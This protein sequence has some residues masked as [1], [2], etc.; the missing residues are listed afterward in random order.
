[1]VVHS[2]EKERQISMKK[3]PLI[4]SMLVILTAL[5]IVSCDNSPKINIYTVTFDSD[6][7]SKVDP[8]KIVEGE[9]AVRPEA[10]EKGGYSFEGWLDSA[11]SVF[12]F[13][14]KITSSITLKAQWSAIK[15]TYTVTFDSDEGS[16]VDPQTVAEGQ[17]AVMPEKAPQKTGYDFRGW[18]KDG[19]MYSFDETP[20]TS[21]I[22]L[23]A[24]WS[25]AL[26]T[27]TITFVSNGGTQVA[28]QTVNEGSK[29][30]RPA[31]PEKD[32]ASFWGWYRNLEDLSPFDFENETVTSDITLY[33]GWVEDV[34]VFRVTFDSKGG[35]E[36]EQQIVAEGYTATEPDA[37]TKENASFDGWL[38]SSGKPF[39]FDTKITQDITLTANWG[40]KAYTVTFDS[41]GGSSVPSQSVIEGQKA[42]KPDDPTREGCRFTGWFRSD[43]VK[44][45]FDSGITSDITLYATWE[46]ITDVCTVIFMVDGT[47]YGT[48]QTVKKWG[49][50]VK[51]EKDPEKER[52]YFIN[53]VRDSDDTAF[54]FE[55]DVVST[56][57]LTLKAT[58]DDEEYYTVTFNS[59]GGSPI[60]SLRIKKGE[61]VKRPANPTKD[62][63]DFM[64]WT[65]DGNTEY[66]FNDPVESDLTLTAKW[67][68]KCY[69]VAYTAEDKI[70]FVQTVNAGGRTSKPQ[71]PKCSDVVKT[72]D[73]WT[74]DGTTAFNFD[75]PINSNITL[76]AVWRD[77]RVG[78]IGPAGGYIFYD[79]DADNADGNKDGLISSEC[80]WRYLEA[81]REDYPETMRWGD[82]SDDNYGTK[83][84]IG[85]GKDNTIR[86]KNRGTK[87]YMVYKI[88]GKEF[89][90]YSDWFVPSRDE[91]NL[92]YENLHKKGL[93]SFR[94]DH[95][96]TSSEYYSD[97]SH[98]Y[99]YACFQDFA[100]G[101]KDGHL[102]SADDYL[103]LI[104]SF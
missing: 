7:G 23:K 90:G 45:S 59:D 82:S 32:K 84:D 14:T 35:S 38:D 30:T 16:P 13:K 88:W 66:T 69:H 10:P 17:Y 55:N 58:W 47:Q 100:S 39:D 73:F 28:S 65:D 12:D 91:L 50:V 83:Y 93:G 24:Q 87:D 97:G 67:M 68:P 95:Y 36:V 26:K 86:L 20:V 104:R 60:S 78:D 89:Y 56:G 54:D 70:I 99:Y 1:M 49:K 11:G 72:F 4:I 81:A 98:S 46:N 9:K 27:Y 15:K 2:I 71:N 94:N 76:K 79:C 51:P 57:S 52:Y 102:R 62:S 33:A 22:T 37:P 3:M 96:W 53:W 92:M 63:Y 42:E 8:Q 21:D 103:R 77:Y 48:S 43:G 40:D 85:T 34:T 25:T 101:K 41:K 31:D 44:F 6:G 5:F 18:F 29:V 75:T 80:G 74:L 19:E 64:V 61:K